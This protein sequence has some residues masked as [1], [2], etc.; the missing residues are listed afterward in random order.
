[1]ADYIQKGSVLDYTATKDLAVGDVVVLKTRVGVAID[2]IKKGAVGSV[3]VTGVFSFPL[4]SGDTVEQGDAVYWDGSAITK[5]STSATPA[6]F[7]FGLVDETTVE[8]KIG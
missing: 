7:V 6:G 4:K 2:A 5:T 3:M 8:V 1:M